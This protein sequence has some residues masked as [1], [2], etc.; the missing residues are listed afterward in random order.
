MREVD[1]LT[2]EKYGIL[3]IL[4]MENAAHATA[5]II[6]EK[7]GGSAKGKTFIILCGKGNNG[8]DGAALARILWT[9]GGNCFVYLFGKV[10]ETKG[11]AKINF[12]ILKKIDESEET[13]APNDNCLVLFEDYQ[14]NSIEFIQEKDDVIIDGLFGTGLSEPIRG[15]LNEFVKKVNASKL[16]FRVLTVSLD[17][18]SG[19]NADSQNLI[20]K[21]IVADLTVTFTAPKLAN[22]LPPASHFNGELHIANIGSPQELIDNCPSQTFLAEKEDARTW[23][24]QTKFSKSSYKNKRGNALLNCR[25]KKLHWSGGFGWKCGDAKRCWIGYDCD[26]RISSKIG[27]VKSVAG[28]YDARCC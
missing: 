3:S 12:E 4:L 15:K 22:V 14:A 7:L 11:D 2:T 24:Y 1:R 8:G 19:L 16:F 27:F 18:P 23:L 5:R 9:L 20:D 10:D 25:F 17:L 26:E 13:N 28:S 6:T 21:N